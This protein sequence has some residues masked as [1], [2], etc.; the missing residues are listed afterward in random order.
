MK[1]GLL[2]IPDYY[3]ERYPS[4]S[5]SIGIE[6]VGGVTGKGDKAEYELLSTEQTDSLKWL[7]A[8][9]S[10]ALSLGGDDVYRH[11]EIGYK[12]RTEASSASW[13]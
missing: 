6:L 4:N 12:N 8:Q 1:C 5:D 7:V 10:A 9:L 13:R 11:S 2:Y 3:P